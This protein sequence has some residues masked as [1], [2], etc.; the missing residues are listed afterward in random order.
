MNPETPIY[1]MIPIHPIFELLKDCVN[2][3]A[4]FNLKP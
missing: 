4:T 2:L 1:P 3:K